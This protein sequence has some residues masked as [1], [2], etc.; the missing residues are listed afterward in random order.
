M[1]NLKINWLLAKIREHGFGGLFIRA[2]LKFYRVLSFKL[3]KIM[4]LTGVYNIDEEKLVSAS[5]FDSLEALIESFRIR[6]APLFFVDPEFRTQY[7]QLLSQEY[8]DE[9]LNQ[10]SEILSH[11]FS[12]LGVD[13]EFG[14]KIDWHLDP[15]SGYRWRKKFFADLFP[16]FN[17]RD[18][19]DGK[20]PYELSRFQHLTLLGIA[21]WISEDEKYTKEFIAELEDWFE[22]NP[23]LVGVNW[24][25]TMDVAIR[26]VN[27]IW[28]Y[29]FFRKSPKLEKYFEVKLLKSLLEHGRYILNHLEKDSI[30]TNHYL[31]DLVGLVYIGVFLSEFRESKRWYDFGI[32]ELINEMERQVYPDGVGYEGS[33]SY[34]RLAAEL[35]LSATLLILLNEQRDI[36]ILRDEGNWFHR[37]RVSTVFPEWYMRRLEKMIEFVIYYTKPDGTA[38]QI[39]DN[40]D[41]RLHILSRYGDWDRLDHRYLLSA[42]AIL[43]NRPDFKEGA[44]R[45]YEEAFWLLGEEG[46]SRFN[47]FKTG[48]A[49]PE[50]KAFFQGGFYIMRHEDL[51]MIVDCLSDN[52]QA[53][54]GH[55]HN[56]R[57]SFELFAYDRSFIIDPGAYIYTADPEWR[58]IFRSTAYHNTIQVD[59]QEQNEFDSFNLFLLGR[60]TQVKV[61]G[62]QTSD[63]Y[64][65]L[66]TEH[67]GYER[68]L[69]SITHRRQIFFNKQEGYW[70][71]KDILTGN[72]QFQ[73]QRRHE[74]ALNLH[75]APLEIAIDPA[76]PL[77]VVASVRNSASMIVFPF[78]SDGLELSVEQGWISYSYGTK[79]KTP[80]VIYRKSANTPVEFLTLFYPYLGTRPKI[81]LSE[82]QKIA[83]TFMEGKS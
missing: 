1:K 10:A 56:S 66:D 46:L 65:F 82:I 74:F 69:D 19:T 15:R 23:Y 47:S 30:K 27:I 71:I 58:N 5:K 79:V 55:R 40:D 62:W 13:V 45:F 75:F 43:F 6:S 21:Y 72:T 26:A 7:V 39:G 49:K 31:S 42:G 24:T 76:N 9:M 48:T 18:N 2:F 14:E 4:F 22:E 81:D 20:M 37:M 70:L 54:L 61:N 64:D 28:G 78:R 59:G 57:L 32:R 53:P 68:L 12:I 8:R 50:S 16:V 77:S 51:Y 44:G 38:P 73:S 83:S 25:C 3:E 52:P 36:S 41:G 17:V 67:S 34:H 63:E 11:K 80:L 29:H 35:F 60:Q 33:I